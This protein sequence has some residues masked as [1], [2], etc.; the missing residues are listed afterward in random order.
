MNSKKYMRD[1][2]PNM[3]PS[4]DCYLSVKNDIFKIRNTVSGYVFF[5]DLLDNLKGSISIGMEDYLD[6]SKTKEV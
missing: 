6:F 4:M 5:D 3:K 2:M 1:N